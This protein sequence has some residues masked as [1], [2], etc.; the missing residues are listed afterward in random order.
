[1][2]EISKSEDHILPSTE[3]WNM[4]FN[5]SR[6]RIIIIILSLVLVEFNLERC[7]SAECGIAEDNDDARLSYLVL[8]FGIK[9]NILYKSCIG[10][11]IKLT[12]NDSFSDLILT[13]RTC[14]EKE[15]LYSSRVSET[16]HFS[17]YG[18]THGI[19]KVIEPIS[20]P[21]KGDKSPNFAILKLRTMISLQDGDGNIPIC[22]PEEKF[23][24]SADMECYVPH[25][26]SEMH[27]TFQPFFKIIILPPN[28][29]PTHPA[30]FP[31]SKK[32][33][34]CG[35]CKL[36][37]SN[38]TT[39]DLEKHKVITEGAPLLCRINNTDYQY[40]IYDWTKLHKVSKNTSQPIAIFTELYPFTI[41]VNF[42][43]SNI[44]YITSDSITI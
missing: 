33:Q 14:L 34:L 10:T 6:K 27:Y 31:V 13:S 26:S 44:S 30:H 2:C 43:A 7:W 20:M 36:S 12:F 28:K 32:N 15:E 21:K 41:I 37:A 23:P 8:I 25:I 29:W 35:T 40:G 17:W 42:F 11:M 4:L 1:M 19:V 38:N 16:L 9:D 39:I 24:Y 18:P 22:L 3:N 5:S